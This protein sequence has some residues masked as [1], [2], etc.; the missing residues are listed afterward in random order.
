AL[1]DMLLEMDVSK[2]NPEA[3]PETTELD[4][5]KLLSAAPA[6]QVI[7]TIAE[8]GILPGAL[9]SHPWLARSHLD[10]NR[11]G[12]LDYMR[13][14]GGKGLE[15]LSDNKLSDILKDWGFE[16]KPLAD[17]KAWAAPDL[18]TLRDKVAVK[19][20]GIEWSHNQTEWGSQ[21]M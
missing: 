15:R 4:R 3:I 9:I 21:Q 7:I 8:D 13:I 12:L 1:L 16:K 20:P 2:F 14:T 10:N 5:Q 17:G 18:Q 19:Y 6:D 11:G